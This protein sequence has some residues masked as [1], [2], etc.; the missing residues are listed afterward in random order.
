M[1]NFLTAQ[2]LTQ[3]FDDTDEDEETVRIRNE[4]KVD[5]IPYVENDKRCLYDLQQS[6]H[7]VLGNV[8]SHCLGMLESLVINTAVTFVTH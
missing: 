2:L 1:H 6:T 3:D 8:H 7:A 5:R 4:K